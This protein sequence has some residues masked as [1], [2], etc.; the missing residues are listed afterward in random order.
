VSL[1]IQRF[2]PVIVILA[3]LFVVL[4]RFGDRPEETPLQ[5]ETAFNLTLTI[6]QSFEKCFVS[7]PYPEQCP[8]HRERLLKDRV[9]IGYGLRHDSPNDDDS[10]PYS[11]KWIGGGCIPTEYAFIVVM[12]CPSCREKQSEIAEITK[13]YLTPRKQAA[14]MAGESAMFWAGAQ[15]QSFYHTRLT[16]RLDW[17]RYAI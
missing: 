2:G 7:Q 5:E 15:D 4:G 12:Y 9:R 10:Y 17:R 14:I 16:I 3:L 1:F 11:N 13:Y 8:I 6:Q